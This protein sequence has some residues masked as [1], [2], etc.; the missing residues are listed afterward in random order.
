MNFL[1][2]Q[3]VSKVSLRA[4]LYIVSDSQTCECIHL[5]L[6]TECKPI[7]IIKM[8]R[9]PKNSINHRNCLQSVGICY[10]VIFRLGS[11]GA[12]CPQTRKTSLVKDPYQLHYYVSQSCIVVFC[13]LDAHVCVVPSES[14]VPVCPHIDISVPTYCHHISSYSHSS[15]ELSPHR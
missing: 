2:I 14:S 7:L 11:V 15:S 5:F 8:C 1:Q 10:K 4:E 13:V 3:S 9:H 6:K 12:I